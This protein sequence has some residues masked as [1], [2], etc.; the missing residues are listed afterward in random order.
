M[1]KL[2]LTDCHIRPLLLTEVRIVP[3]S[4]LRHQ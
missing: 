1:A 4:R 2:S 3:L